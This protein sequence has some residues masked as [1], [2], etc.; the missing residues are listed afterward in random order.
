MPGQPQPGLGYPPGYAAP[1]AVTPAAPATTEGASAPAGQPAY[2]PSFAH[3]YAPPPGPQPAATVP[4]VPGEVTQQAQA[5]VKPDGALPWIIGGAGV[6]C[7][8]MGGVFTYL[9]QQAYADT[10]AQY[11]PERESAGRTYSYLQFVGYGLGAA[12]VATAAIMLLKPTHGEGQG[13]VTLAPALGPQL[14]GAE[15]TV[16]Y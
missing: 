16:R 2:P 3:G 6:V 9:Y 7:L 12:G 8:G 13:A 14:A 10:R 1:P 11:N 15:L 5:P 4:P